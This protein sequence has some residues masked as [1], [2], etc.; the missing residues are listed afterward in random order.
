MK[1]NET[2]QINE[3]GIYQPK[4]VKIWGENHFRMD[5]VNRIRK[6]VIEFQPDVILHELWWDDAP[7]F[8]S[9]TD[10]KVIPLE[11]EVGK[12][13]NLKEQFKSRERSMVNRLNRAFNNHNYNRI[14]VVIGDTHLR[15]IETEEL[16][17]SS[18]VLAWA[19]R[20]RATVIR[21]FYKEI[22]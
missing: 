4:E 21:S 11:R 13:S 7:W 16:G 19:K 1:L 9:R 10:A 20:K 22:A 5:E 8:Q 3:I 14:A 18:P 17:S 6:E 12:F 2:I 15:S